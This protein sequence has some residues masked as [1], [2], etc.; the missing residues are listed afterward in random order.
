MLFVS[1]CWRNGLFECSCKYLGIWYL[2]FLQEGEL[3]K[4]TAMMVAMYLGMYLALVTFVRILYLLVEITEAV[5][6]KCACMQK[7]V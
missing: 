7:D 2:I 3:I 1:K 6:M 4:L 5:M